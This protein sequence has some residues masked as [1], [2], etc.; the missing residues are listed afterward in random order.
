MQLNDKTNFNTM[1]VPNLDEIGLINIVN[2]RI[3]FGNAADFGFGILFET[4]II[5]EL[6]P[7]IFLKN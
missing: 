7:M 4:A 1:P 3:W 2:V 6:K 5:D